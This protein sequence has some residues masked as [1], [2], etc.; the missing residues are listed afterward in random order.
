M[1]EIQSNH[2]EVLQRGAGLN[3]ASSNV[4]EQSIKGYF[5]FN[6]LLTLTWI[7]Y[8]RLFKF[9]RKHCRHKTRNRISVTKVID[10]VQV[11]LMSIMG[12][13]E[14]LTCKCIKLKTQSWLKL[15]M[16]F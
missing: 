2:L 16:I 11:K 12:E 15:K 9:F 5:K 1:S 14:V 7:R 6:E 10:I 8:K 13:L 4:F 3:N